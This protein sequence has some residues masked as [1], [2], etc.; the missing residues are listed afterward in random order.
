MNNCVEVEKVIDQIKKEIIEKGIVYED[1]ILFV[2]DTDIIQG[3]E[4]D[5]ALPIPE[6]LYI[7]ELR[8]T[9]LIVFV[10]KCIRKACC[11]LILPLLEEQNHINSTLR[12]EL[13]NLR[14]QVKKQEEEISRLK[15]K[16][17]C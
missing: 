11:F 5:Y 15:D 6:L 8:G 3:E 1:E 16:V 12:I 14:K 4:D 13:I 17:N 10:K 2:D 7:R 9:K